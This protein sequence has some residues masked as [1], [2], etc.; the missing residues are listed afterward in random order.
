MHDCPHC[1]ASFEDESDFLAHLRD[2]HSAEFGAVDRRRLEQLRGGDSGGISRSALLL[3]GLALAVVGIVAFVTV[4]L[5]GSSGDD[6]VAAAQTPTAVG[7]THYHGTMEMV[8]LGDRIDFSQDQ[9]QLRANAFHFEG[10]DGQ[11]WHGH[12]RGV[13]LEWAM[14]SLGIEVTDSSVTF[15]G[16]TYRDSDAAYAV[17]VTVN[18]ESVDPE[19]YLLQGASDARNADAQGDHIRI[20]VESV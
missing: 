13:T 3:S 7:S 19:T 14:S 8:V 6:S 1:S 20:V 11:V 10:G 4:G 9:Y 17:S 2:D 12:A 15:E 18:G 16:T 5:G